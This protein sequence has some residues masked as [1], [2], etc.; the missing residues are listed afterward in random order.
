MLIYYI[1]CNKSEKVKYLETGAGTI[2]EQ[3]VEVAQVIV[4]ELQLQCKELYI[5]PT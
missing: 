5:I 2:M 3:E 4:E 1:K